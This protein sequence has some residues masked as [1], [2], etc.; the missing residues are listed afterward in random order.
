M[1]IHIILTI[2]LSLLLSPI[3]L[4]ATIQQSNMSVKEQ[5]I[6]GVHFSDKQSLSVTDILEGNKTKIEAKLGKKLSLK[7]RFVLHVAKNKLKKAKQEGHLDQSWKAMAEDN[8]DSDYWLGVLLGILLGLIG[9][10][11]ALLIGNN[12]VLRGSLY[13][14]LVLLLILLLAVA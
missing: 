9:V 11:I 7:E 14:F 6:Y 4:K 3:F 12:N 1:K 10:L 2:V 5:K 13:G 8:S